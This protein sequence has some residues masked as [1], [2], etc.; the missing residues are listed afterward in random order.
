M[1]RSDFLEGVRMLKF[2][3]IHERYDAGELSQFEAAELLGV[4]ER[5]FRRW[6]GRYGDDGYPSAGGR[7][8]Q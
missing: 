6:C 5:T 2:L 4:C 8:V 7:L 1:R 3:K